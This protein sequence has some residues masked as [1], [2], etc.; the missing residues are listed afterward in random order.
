MSSMS[1]EEQIKAG[2]A[3]EKIRLR[4]KPSHYLL[5]LVLE[6][7]GDSL[8]L[9]SPLITTDTP[10]ELE[11]YSSTGTNTIMKGAILSRELPSKVEERWYLS[12][13]LHAH[14]SIFNTFLPL[15]SVIDLM[16]RRVQLGV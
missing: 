8:V 12:R 13:A 16:H 2:T 14:L 9:L 3:I 4:D 15:F 7:L 6:D 5:A 1:I 10:W 11:D